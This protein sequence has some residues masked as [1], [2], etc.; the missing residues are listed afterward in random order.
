MD[1]KSERKHLLKICE[2]HEIK[3]ILTSYLRT[4]MDTCRL[5]VKLFH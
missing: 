1:L 5:D 4:G 2:Q 3:R